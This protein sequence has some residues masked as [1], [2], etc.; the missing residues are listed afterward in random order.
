MVVE[1]SSLHSL[2]RFGADE[3]LARHSSRYDKEKHLGRGAPKE[4][5]SDVVVKRGNSRT[6]NA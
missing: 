3:I 6:E 2:T 1:K 5:I 4:E